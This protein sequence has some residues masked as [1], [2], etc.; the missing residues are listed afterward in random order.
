MFRSEGFVGA[1]RYHV[2]LDLLVIQNVRLSNGSE[3]SFSELSQFDRIAGSERFPIGKWVSTQ[4]ACRYGA[5]RA[6]DDYV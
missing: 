3:D 1:L 4:G 6:A 2:K 5:E